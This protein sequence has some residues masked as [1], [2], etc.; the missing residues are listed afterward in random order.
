MDANEGVLT[1]D[2]ARTVMARKL[3]PLPIATTA[4]V[5]IT[6]VLTTFEFFSPAVLNTLERDPVAFAAGQWWR[7]ITPLFVRDGIWFQYVQLVVI[8]IMG[9]LIERRFGSVRWLILYF[10]PG[11][12]GELAGMT[13]GPI[14]ASAAHGLFGLVGAQF[15]R[16]LWHENDRPIIAL[17]ALC[18]VAGLIGYS[19]ADV[20]GAV[21]AGTLAGFPLGWMVP[22]RARARGWGPYIGVAGLLGALVLSALR[23]FHGPPFI[24]G[25]LLA[26][27]ML[28]WEHARGTG[29]AATTN[30]SLE[31]RTRMNADERG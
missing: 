5:I 27:L 18:T 24:V 29:R 22:N 31:D 3:L 6:A 28:W 17:L 21:V 7:I 1:T 9:T 13:W 16:L 25:A 2:T 15:M 26:A 12:V 30:V 14:G 11:M 23:D 10:V 19:L 20:T 4:V 8:A